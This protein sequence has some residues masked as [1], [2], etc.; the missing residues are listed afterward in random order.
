MGISG[1][2]SDPIC[3]RLAHMEGFLLVDWFLEVA[4]WYAHI[5]GID[6]DNKKI[7]IADGPVCFGCG[8][9]ANVWPRVPLLETIRRYNDPEERSFCSEFNEIKERLTSVIARNF[10]EENCFRKNTSG[11]ELYRKLIFVLLKHFTAKWGN[12]E[13]IGAV[14]SK[15][16]V[17]GCLK[18]ME[19]V[20]FH[21]DGFPKKTVRHW[22]LKLSSQRHLSLERTI[23]NANNIQRVSQPKEQYDHLLWTENAKRPKALKDLE[24]AEKATV[25][26]VRFKEVQDDLKSEER[27]RTLGGLNAEQAI[28]AGRSVAGLQRVTAGQFLEEDEPE[29][30]TPPARGRGVRGRGARK[31]KL[32]ALVPDTAS[33]QP[34]KQSSPGKEPEAKAAKVKKFDLQKS[35][36]TEMYLE[37]LHDDMKPGRSLR[38]VHDLA[39]APDVDR[40]LLLTS[41]LGVYPRY[42][43]GPS[44]SS[45]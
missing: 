36:N 30:A 6:I 43:P 22:I 9:T 13:S 11:I 21:K 18:D 37:V 35:D 39:A 14:V 17:P 23:L 2:L 19:G 8:V 1:Y 38:G 41:I 25:L 32:A 40:W 4:K 3:S 7:Q 33:Q 29:E 15:L 34:G 24:E 10:P 45:M 28:A 26:D 5:V 16:P 42:R 12:P 20:L 44:G 27:E 31:S